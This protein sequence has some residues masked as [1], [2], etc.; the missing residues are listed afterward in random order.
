MEIYQEKGIQVVI[1]LGIILNFCKHILFR[2]SP[3]PAMPAMLDSEDFIIPADIDCWY[4]LAQGLQE[5]LLGIA[6][7]EYS[8][9]GRCFISLYNTNVPF[10]VF[11]MHKQ[12]RFMLVL[13]VYEL[14]LHN[15]P[16]DDYYF[17]F[18]VN[19]TVDSNDAKEKISSRI[20]SYN[21]G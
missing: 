14:R 15:N 12:Q 19:N 18:N 1:C 2:N 4:S 5:S 13:P 6:S 17:I 21:C 9:I 8:R 20:I 7:I 16:H 3:L 10:R 11:N